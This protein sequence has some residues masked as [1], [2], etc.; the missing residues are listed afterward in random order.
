MTAAAGIVLAWSAV[1]LGRDPNRDHVRVLLDTSCSMNRPETDAARLAKLATLLLFDL[2]E[3]NLRSGNESFVVQPFDEAWPA[4]DGWNPTLSASTQHLVDPASAPDPRVA[5]QRSLAA[6]QYDARNTYYAPG[7]AWAIDDLEQTPGGLTDRR[8]IVLVTDGLPGDG[9]AE[10][11]AGEKARIHA[12]APRMNE[13]NIRLYIIAVGDRA[14][15]HIGW[16]RALTTPPKPEPPVGEAFETPKEGLLR[17]MIAVFGYGFGYTA[18]DLGKRGPGITADLAGSAEASPLRS[19]VVAYTEQPTPPDLTVSPPPSG[20]SSPLWPRGLLGTG[21]GSAHSYRLWGEGTPSPGDYRIG[22]PTPAQLV[23]LRPTRVELEV[24]DPAEPAAVMADVPFTL[25]AEVFPEGGTAGNTPELN[26][27]WQ[28]SQDG[29]PVDNENTAG[30]SRW[31]PTT[32]RRRYELRPNFP[33]DPWAEGFT[34]PYYQGLVEIQGRL[35]EVEVVSL[36]DGYRVN[37]YPRL[38]LDPSPPEANAVRQQFWR[39]GADL[40]LRRG[41]LGC[42][43][44][45]FDLRKGRTDPEGREHLPTLQHPDR[46][47]LRI[48]LAQPT[49]PSGLE[50]ATVTVDIAGRTPGRPLKSAATLPAI[51]TWSSPVPLTEAE[52]LGGPHRIC[53]Q[54]GQARRGGDAQLEVG[55]VLDEAPYNRFPEVITPFVLRVKVAEPPLLRRLAPLLCVALSSGLLLVFLRL[56]RRR[57]RLPPDLRYEI[58]V[59]GAGPLAWTTHAFPPEPL[60]VRWL[61]LPPRHPLRSELGEI[62]LGDIVPVDRELYAFRPDDDPPRDNGQPVELSGGRAMLRVQREYTVRKDGK[63]Y[64]FRLT[65]A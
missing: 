22:P 13:A 27:Y 54:M 8:V 35:N 1:A 11:M 42:A 37:V 29:V 63:M 40:D 24:V 38:H 45:T 2:A 57:L 9:R 39:R 55:F 49:L 43:S 10:V 58:A 3:P 17:V 5:L 56:L 44:F 16:L 65:Y 7:I 31:D 47:P 33:N 41:D 53:V 36:T 48:T 60:L 4:P 61:G 18:E 28:A 19:M 21:V 26:L 34:G 23:V 25:Q 46:Y 32:R 51:P 52:L 6:L 30:R 20:K 50:D 59:S 14:N 12:L 15:D 62:R 64:H